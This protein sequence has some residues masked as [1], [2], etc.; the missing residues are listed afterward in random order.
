MLKEEF[1]SF[2]KDLNEKELAI[3]EKKGSDYA[4]SS[5][6]LSNFKCSAM[7]CDLPVDKI[8]QVMCA[9][10]FCRWVQLTSGKTPKNESLMDTIIDSAA[11][12]KLYNAYLNEKSK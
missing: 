12:L 3:F 8:F 2:V 7:M 6:V 1:I 10:K 9:I 11:Y 4:S 5:D